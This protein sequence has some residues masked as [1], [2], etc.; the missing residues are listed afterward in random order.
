MPRL[1]L[2]L[3]LNRGGIIPFAPL[4]LNPLLAYEAESSMVA[5]FE[6]PTLD[7][8]PSNPS[9]L[10]PITAT[11]A[12]VATYTDSN[13]VVQTAS[14]NTVRVDHVQGEELTPTKYQRVGYTDFSDSTYPYG[15]QTAGTVAEGEGYE[16]QPSVVFTAQTSW[17]YIATGIPTKAGVTYTGSIW[18]RRI[19]GSEPIVIQHSQSATGVNSSFKNVTTEWTRIELQFLGNSSDGN[20][21]FGVKIQ[22]LNAAGTSVEIA[23]P[24]V[25]EGTSASDFVPNTTGAPLLFANATY[26]PRVP[27]ILVEPS[28]TN[29]VDYSNLDTTG[30]WYSLGFDITQNEILS[31]D[32]LTNGIKMEQTSTTRNINGRFISSATE[33]SVTYSFWVKKGSGATHLNKFIIRNDNVSP[34]NQFGAIN[35]ATGE[36]I[37]NDFGTGNLIVEEYPNGWFKV[38]ATRDTDINLGDAIRVYPPINSSDGTNEIGRYNYTFGHQLEYGSAATS[39]IPTNGST[40]TRNADQLVIE[41]SDFTDFFNQSEGTVYFEG[42]SNSRSDPRLFEFSDGTTSNRTRIDINGGVNFRVLVYSGSMIVNEEVPFIGASSLFRTALSFKVNDLE[43]NL[44][45]ASV[46][47]ETPSSLPTL[48]QLHVGSN[49]DGTAGYLNGHIKRL[50][51]WPYHSDDL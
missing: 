4:A 2:G 3:G 16:G 7:L 47:N 37:I 29:L 33:T 28:A 46:I 6:R 45:G 51:Y 42:T 26:A 18:I 24:Q 40:V 35:L 30:I 13:G 12:G 48:D 19:S 25:E 34:F 20:V 27:M 38:K 22:S 17:Q 36:I 11:R 41:G 5:P 50:I 1:G 49:H 39:Y 8:D 21:F 9:S 23:M 15:W 32:G 31:P 10:D 14:P 44:N 43:G